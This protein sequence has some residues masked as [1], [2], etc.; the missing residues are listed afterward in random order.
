MQLLVGV[1]T[2]YGN[3]VV[4][5]DQNTVKDIVINFVSFVAIIEIDNFYA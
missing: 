1:S 2:E 5:C 4:I 3:M